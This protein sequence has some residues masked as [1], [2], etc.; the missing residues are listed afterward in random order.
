MR[1]EPPIEQFLLALKAQ[2]VRVWLDGEALRVSAPSQGLDPALKARLAAR[3]DEVVGFLRRSARAEDGAILPRPAGA[4]AGRL[5]LSFDQQRIWFLQRL[6]PRGVAFHLQ[7]HLVLQARPGDVAAAWGRLLAR[8]EVLRTIYPEGDDGPYQLVGTAGP[9]D[10]RPVD[11]TALPDAELGAALRGPARQALAEPFDLAH[12]PVWRL[13]LFQLSGGRCAV[14]VFVHHIATDGWAMARLNAELAEAVA[15]QREGREPRLAS[16]P[17][18]YADFALWQRQH[19]HGERLREQ[20]TWWCERLAGMPQ[21]LELPTDLPR[22]PQHSGNGSVLTLTLTPALSLAL[23]TLAQRQQVTPY[24]LL[25]ALFKLLL[26]RQTGQ[27]DVVVGSPIAGRARPELEHLQGV[28]VNSL[29]LRTELAPAMPFTDL[30]ARVRETALGAFAH[31]GLPFQMLVDELRPPRDLSRNPLFQAMFNMLVQGASGALAGLP[32]DD[33]ASDGSATDVGDAADAALA[34]SVQVDLALDVLDTGAA[35]ILA[36]NYCTD[37]FERASVVRLAAQYRRAAEAVVAAPAVTGGAVDLL[38]DEGRDELLQRWNDTAQAFDETPITRRLEQQAARHG[39]AVALAFE[40]RTLSYGA[41]DAQ[42]NRLARHLRVQLGLAAAA[43]ARVGIHLQRGPAMLVAVLAVMKAGAAYLPLDPAYPAGRLAFMLQDSGAALLLTEEALRGSLDAGA[44]RIVSVDGDAAAIAAHEATPLASG[45]APDDLAYLLYTSGSTGQPKGVMVHHRAL[46]SFLHAMTLAPGL[47]AQ[48]VL[49]AVTTLS[50]DIAGLE[51]YLPLM[52]GA[53]I[54]LASREVAQDGAALARLIETS[55]AT[56]MQ[57]TPATWRLLLAAGWSGRP[58]L[59]L[60]CGGEALARDLADALLTRCSALW[61]LYGPTETTIWSTAERVGPGRGAVPIGRPI[62][63]TRVY[64]LDAAGAPVPVGV[65]GR[66]FIGGAGV[67][68]GYWG[69]EALTAE[70]FVADPF[71]GPSIGQ[72]GARMYD[73]GDLARWRA[74]GRLEYLGRG[75]TQVK[76]RGYRIELGEIEA[77][78]ARA[79]GVAQAVVLVREDRPGDQRLVAYLVPQPG[80]VPTEEGLRATAAQLLPAFM[81]PAAWVMLP[82][83]PLTPNGKVDRQALPPPRAAAPLVATDPVPPR[84]ETEQ[85]LAAIWR[86]LLHVNQIGVHDNFFD[87]GGHSLL[88]VAL[89]GRLLEAFGIELPVVA[90]FEHPTIAALASRLAGQGPTDVAPDPA[91]AR[92]AAGAAGQGRGDG[93]DAIAV[94]GL[95]GRFPGADDLDA[96]WQL[97][98]DGREAISFFDEATLLAEGSDPSVLRHPDFVPAKGVIREPGHFD[99]GFFKY[100]PADAEAMDPQQRLFLQCA[101]HAL[102]DAGHDSARF[103]GAVGV[104]AATSLNSYTLRSVMAMGDPGQAFLNDKDFLATRVAYKLDLRGPAL[105][106]QTACSA[107]LVALAEA[108][109]SLAAGRCDMA[110]A[111]GVSVGVPV[112]TGYVYQEGGIRTRDGHCRPF[113]AKAD[114]CVGGDGLAVVVLKRLADALADGD[115]VHAVVR[116]WAVNNDGANKVGFTAPS[117]AGQAA[118]IV[119]ALRRAG[120]APGSIGYVETHGTGTVLGDPIELAALNQAYGAGV[121]RRSVALGTLK[122]NIGHLDAAAGIAGF[123]KAVLCL[124]ER[125]LPPS[126]FFE[127]PNPKLAFDD[128]PFYVNASLTDWLAPAGGQPRRAGVS[129]FGIGGTNAHVVLEEAPPATALPVQS[130]QPAMPSLL[131]V[132][133]RTPAALDAATSRL[134]AHLAARPRTALADVAFTLLAGRRLFEQRRFAVC[135]NTSDAADVFAGTAPQRL[136]TGTGSGSRPE[137]VFMF[138]GQGAQ[139]PGMTRGLYVAYQVFRDEVDRCAAL[140]QPHLGLDLR[141]L[142]Y[143]DD[144]TD[145]DSEAGAAARLQRTEHAQPALFVV[146][147]ALARLWMHWGVVPQAMIGHSLGEY[148]A[149]CLSGVITL[150][151]ALAAVA[152]RGRLMQAQPGGAMLAVPLAGVDLATM[153]AGAGLGIAAENTA[154]LTVVSGPHDSIAELGRRL[155]AAGHEARPLQT[156]HAF[157]SPM[158]MPAVA[159]LVDFLRSVA[160]RPPKIPYLSNLSGDWVTDAD[161]T[162]PQAWGRHIVAPVQFASALE[163]LHA[164]RP[165]FVEVGPGNA[166]CTF[167]KASAPTGDP[168][169]VVASTRHPRE[170]RDDTE[171]LLHALGQ[172][173]LAGVTIDAAALSGTPPRRVSLPGYPFEGQHYWLRMQAPPGAP[174]AL[175]GLLDKRADTDQWCYLPAWLAGQPLPVPPAHEAWDGPW[176]VLHHGHG[177]GA[178]LVA[179]LRARGASVVQV[180]PS[181]RLREPGPGHYALEPTEPDSYRKVLD[182]LQAAGTTPRRVVHAFGLS[183]AGAAAEAR[184]FDLAFYSLLYL[185]QALAARFSD[186]MPRLE[187]LSDRLHAVIGDEAL[188]PEAATALGLAR[189]LPQEWPGAVCRVVDIDVGFHGTPVGL[190]MLLG[191]LADAGTEPVVALRGRRRWRPCMEAAGAPVPGAGMALRARGVYVITGGLGGVGLALA[192]HLAHRVQARLVLVGRSAFP[193]PQTWDAW[194]AGHAAD[195]PTCRRIAALRAMQ[196]DGAELLLASADVADEAALRAVAAQARKHFGPVHGVLHAAGVLS[197]PS[198]A[199]IAKLTRAECE[200]QLRPKQVGLRALE[201]AFDSPALELMMVVSSIS[202]VLGGLGLAAYAAANQFM[203]TLVQQR[204]GADRRAWVSVNWDAWHFGPAPVGARRGSVAALA[205][206]PEE[207]V[208]VFDRVLALGAPPQLVVSTADLDRRIE[209]NRQALAERDAPA[210]TPPPAGHTRPALAS[211][212]VAPRTELERAIAEVWQELL[213][214]DQ[215]G[216]YDNFFDLGGHS[217]LAVRAAARLREKLGVSLSMERFLELGTVDQVAWQSLGQVAAG[218]Q[219]AGAAAPAAEGGASSSP[220]DPTLNAVPDAVVQASASASAAAGAE[221]D[222]SRGSSPADA[223]TPPMPRLEPF[224]FG[225]GDRQ[226]FGLLRR[227]PAPRGAGVVLCAPH[228]H[229]FIRCHR[230]LREL[231]HQLALAGFDVL[232]FDYHG[233]GD[234]DGDYEDATLPGC[235]Q[236]TGA[237]IDALV[238][239]AAPRFIAVLGLRVGG[240]VA[241]A[242]VDGRSDVQALALW[243]P[244]VAGADLADDIARIAALQALPPL[245]QQDVEQSDVLAWSVSTELVRGIEGIDLCRALPP[246]LPPLLVLETGT[247]GGGRRLADL[248]RAQGQRAEHCRIDEARVWTREP[249]EAVAPR[250]T[251]AAL[252]AWLQGV[253]PCAARPPE[254]ARTEVRSTEVA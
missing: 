130:A 216:I 246:V 120:A 133:A 106:V 238:A 39:E 102:E 182:A 179:E 77:V 131:V 178:A 116:G 73:T 42:A 188:R 44:A 109:E 228:G 202:T 45:P 100:S 94:I 147:Y 16:L 225:P 249:Y 75:D 27:W 247:E 220:D 206:T 166:L 192:A 80:A 145:G 138:S 46:A 191:E 162:D 163:R 61:N 156:S 103:A 85:R 63:N 78:I 84:S 92:Y 67:A 29:V 125:R 57:A 183:D 241:L 30:L 65:T 154:G 107:S 230:A 104:Y 36:F 52:V 51:L 91:A 184:T 209:R 134:G 24:M 160:L 41:L 193:A 115:T 40:G 117:V 43:P 240:A 105:T 11:L 253:V 47:R 64:L 31:Q 198:L 221:G 60:L 38:G 114:G 21:V 110:L 173:W 98:C 18:Q 143:P 185:M 151:D 244:V 74:D 153:L 108:C 167:A 66:L 175:S 213:G 194:L 86:A 72:P 79:P 1:S 231:G 126:L 168:A 254:G 233:T 195:D 141:E 132:S 70:R 186:A 10:L 218:L 112:I 205:L 239:R 97:L 139:Y 48:D 4:V 71:R 161:A 88:V 6:N 242:A 119:Q 204:R 150:P 111:G 135:R 200:A 217:L 15:A 121:A 35:F 20:L 136:V 229:E 118:C 159:P 165:V 190:P 128:G 187:V 19:L 99:A 137:V 33:D 146:E 169:V 50:F 122:P 235:V 171:V 199:P 197:G 59:T 53:R 237:A 69:R 211:A 2:D 28:L 124:R 89:Q 148:V 96:F 226:L 12:G 55:G 58:G 23:R 174:A 251:Q 56:V 22:P 214:I 26:A 14:F 149:A 212:Y 81:V 87:I 227:P 95:A 76:L 232:S 17:I 177:P 234:S 54:E 90:L 32:S 203:D 189:V 25:L 13:R 236:D 170:R 176:L 243:D 219:Q 196:A 181:D 245:A 224:F 252:L 215:V 140:L 113:D 180:T 5:P 155:A 3:R 37:L 8:H 142:L 34:G 82:A 144:G 83:L 207:G 62:A 68:R 248:A 127:T 250:Q 129:A 164:R 157:H 208:R 93:G 152:L 49:L 101:W 172:L 123:V 9:V 7:T 158:M 201:A 223:R 222:A 210:E